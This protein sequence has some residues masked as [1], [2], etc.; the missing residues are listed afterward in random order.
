ML[1]VG[2]P[3]PFRVI[4]LLGEKSTL[5]SFI[6]AFII[7]FCAQLILDARDFRGDARLYWSLSADLL[8]F[9]YP[10]TIRGYFYPLVLVPFRFL[11][12][13][14][15][16]VGLFSLKIGQSVAYGY[17]FSIAL[18]NLY[19]SVF[20]GTLSTLRRII[21]PILVALIFPGLVSYPLS[22]APAFGML[23][24]SAV[25]VVKA[26]ASQSIMRSFSYILIAGLLSYFSYNTR[27]IYIFSVIALALLVL[28]FFIRGPLY[29]LIAVFIFFAGVSLG[30]A[31]Q[32]AINY[33]YSKTFS[34][35]VETDLGGGSLF[36]HQLAW[37]MIVDRYE[38]YIEPG[39][40]R[41][42]P[43]FYANKA[44]A[45]ILRNHGGFDS[46]SISRFLEMMIE[47][48]L[49]F[50][51]IY[52]RH[53]ASGLDA[54]DGE[55]YTQ[56]PSA[57]KST[58]SLMYLFIVIFGLSQLAISFIFK[59]YNNFV[60]KFLFGIVLLLPSVAI[61]PGAIETRF[62][63][64][65]YCLAYCAISLENIVRSKFILQMLVVVLFVIPVY[66][67]VQHSIKS[68]IYQRPES[69]LIVPINSPE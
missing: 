48:P 66:A 11:F 33:R 35:F 56:R 9:D 39:A 65:V 22:D 68:P 19:H 1:A 42:T 28:V 29:K 54:R 58:R 36:V 63:F 47:H 20:G 67:F 25:M 43:V 26:L 30:S 10:Q 57:E 44:G 17:L 15:E 46:L 7:F 14:S 24:A 40:V 62:F 64:P 18:P 55:V 6:S 34:P 50:S 41:G 52:V 59:G 5:V 38:T 37:G 8:Q 51:G 60:R 12:D 45:E 27:T 16:S 61:I 23:V 13:F 2:T 31:P 32:M 4:K 53:I 49:V 69:Y 3:H 21:P